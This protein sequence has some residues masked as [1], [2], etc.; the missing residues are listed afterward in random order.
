M[1]RS[2]APGRDA[3][4]PGSGDALGELTALLPYLVEPSAAT[5]IG[6]VPLGE[7]PSTRGCEEHYTN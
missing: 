5:N 2:K 6:L 3:R 4:D 1:G 7:G